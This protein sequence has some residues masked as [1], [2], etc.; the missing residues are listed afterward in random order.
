MPISISADVACPVPLEFV[1]FVEA[2]AM[3]VGAS[4]PRKTLGENEPSSFSLV[5][6]FAKFELAQIEMNK[7]FQIQLIATPN[8]SQQMFAQVFALVVGLRRAGLSVTCSGDLPD[9]FPK[10]EISIAPVSEIVF[11]KVGADHESKSANRFQTTPEQLVEW[12]RGFNSISRFDQVSQSSLHTGPVIRHGNYVVWKLNHGLMI[13]ARLD[14]ELL[15][16]HQILGCTLPEIAFRTG[17]TLTPTVT[18]R[19]WGE[20]WLPHELAGQVLIGLVW[21]ADQVS[22]ITDRI[23]RYRIEEPAT[24]ARRRLTFGKL[25]SKSFRFDEWIKFANQFHARKNSAAAMNCLKQAELLAKSEEQISEVAKHKAV[26]RPPKRIRIPV[27]KTFQRLSFRELENQIGATAFVLFLRMEKER[28]NAYAYSDFGRMPWEVVQADNG[29][30]AARL[31]QKAGMTKQVLQELVRIGSIGFFPDSIAGLFSFQIE[32]RQFWGG[33]T[34]GAYYV[35]G[36]PDAV[37]V[38]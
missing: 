12:Y 6:E 32:G 1:A 17:V 38:S 24:I 7:R 18:R 22:I 34:T 26:L 30:V 23:H 29:P 11:R 35:E 3:Y 5:T 10:E 31:A 15:M 16:D 19:T 8:L 9:C 28:S 37:F 20:A 21:L 36:I 2:V 27:S 33:R 25:A 4:V 13:K 14:G